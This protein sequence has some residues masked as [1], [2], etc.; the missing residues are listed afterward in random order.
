MTAAA[1]EDHALLS[2]QRTAA[3]VTR[4]GMIDFLCMPRFDSPALFCALLGDE[5]NGH[6]TLGI[7]DAEVTG[8]RYVPGTMILETTWEGPDGA[9]VV[10]DFL[11]VDG[12]T[13]D[14]SAAEVFGSHGDLVRTVRCT[15][16]SVVVD[17]QL[18][19]RFDYGATVPW[20]RTC[21]DAEGVDALTAVAG[22]DA[23]ALHGP[24]LTA[25]GFSHRG[26]H[27]V[28]EGHAE[29]WA[30][31]WHPSW[32]E[33]PGAPQVAA[34]RETTAA[35]WTEWL[36][37]V[38][39]H[40]RFEK[41]VERSLLVLKALSHRRT[42]GIVAAPTTSLPES[43]GGERNWDY[44]FCWLRDAA[45]SLQALLAHGHMDAAVSWRDWLLRA[46][47]GDPQRMQ[48]MYRVGGERHLDERELTHLPGY[49]GSRPVR[50]GNGAAAQFQGDV[51]GEVMIALSHLREAGVEEDP[52]S[53]PLQRQ[54][55]AFAAEHV[56]DRDQGLWEMR[57]EAQYFTHSRVMIWAAFDRGIDAV[58]RHGLP[59]HRHAVDRWRELRDRLRTEILERG[60]D[61]SGAFT[62]T[63]G[64]PDVDAALLQIP[65]TG[66][67][68][69]D[70]PHMLATVA[71]IEK[72]LLTDDGLVLRYR[73]HGQDGLSGEEHPFLVCCFWLVA[74]YAGSGRMD[75]AC[76]LL[77]RVLACGND[78]H[79]FSEE[80]DGTAGRM[81]GNFPQ[82]FSHI[83]LVCAV[84]AVSG[85]PWH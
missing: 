31:T 19:V 68:T 50:E 80:Y 59:A 42:G 32:M 29:S 6:W 21:T 66:F 44:R 38:N 46:I 22:S 82:A 63:Y 1:I 28:E 62:Q 41:H 61:A 24:S 26:H 60:T 14:G 52:W 35:A 75:D 15:R 65:H 69:P 77:D 7:A 81:A 40:R 78:L 2:D 16:G 33:V 51:V 37:Q 71:R 10:T 54:L 48:I 84:D 11:V 47:A 85:N 23:I 83:G 8:R 27:R 25:E 58:E 20:L 57:G 49:E 39:V 45:L 56:D 74:Q 18:R 53:W 12:T 13:R 70:D 43:F 34:V 5:D 30:L 9:A 55:L 4:E 64:G 72:E 67:C 36:G 3:L 79:L 76:E 73:P 17:Q